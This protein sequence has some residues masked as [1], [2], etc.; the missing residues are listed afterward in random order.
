MFVIEV[1]TVA[2]LSQ[3]LPSVKA[4]FLLFCDFARYLMSSSGLEA[5]CY[6]FV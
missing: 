6:E 1:Y 5:A 3:E 4:V 2:S